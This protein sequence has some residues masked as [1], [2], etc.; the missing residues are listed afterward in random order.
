MYKFRNTSRAQEI[1][2]QKKYFNKKNDA[3]E[4]SGLSNT[5]STHK[6]FQHTKQ[7]NTN[8]TL[9][10]PPIFERHSARFICDFDA[11]LI[12]KTRIDKMR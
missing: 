2:Y 6:L 5:R 11:I 3:H 7:H 9:G 1:Y 12:N 8:C 4:I 10:T